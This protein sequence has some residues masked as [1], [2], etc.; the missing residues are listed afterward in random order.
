MITTPG[1]ESTFQGA[2]DYLLEAVEKALHPIAE[3]RW[4]PFEHLDGINV[5]PRDWSRI[6][7]WIH[8]SQDRFDGFVV[9]HGTDTLASAASGVAFMLGRSMAK[10][11][12]FTGSQATISVPHGDA[13]DN[14]GRACFVAAHPQ[15][16]GEVQVHF[17]NQVLRAVRAEKADDRLFQGFRSTGWPEL[18]QVSEKLLINPYALAGRGAKDTDCGFQPYFASNI[19]VIYIVPGLPVRFFEAVFSESA[20]SEGIDG[21]IVHTPGAGNI[22][23][24]DEHNF[25]D[26]IKR[27]VDA[28]MPVLVTSQVPIN[29]YTQP[30]YEMSRAVT[31]YGAILAGNM[32]FPAAHAKF[33]WVIGC[34]NHEDSW[35]G[36]T[37]MAQIK[38]RMHHNYQGEQSDP[39]GYAGALEGVSTSHESSSGGTYD[40]QLS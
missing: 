37:R 9:A 4:I 16:P 11:V 27:A 12:V 25:R 31:D 35:Y 34:V 3:A 40:S 2:D 18:A 38:T 21:L 1:G 24:R 32:T 13:L 8:E 26:F 7:T 5:T 17:G 30:Q 28:G 15:A 20:L 39:E 6:A 23:Y 19:L 22:P 10:P 33:V 29:P 14:L 36:E